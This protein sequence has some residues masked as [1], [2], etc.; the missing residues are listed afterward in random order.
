MLTVRNRV[1]LFRWHLFSMKR[2]LEMV[3]GLTFLP[4]RGLLTS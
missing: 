2:T 4:F 1:P 3:S